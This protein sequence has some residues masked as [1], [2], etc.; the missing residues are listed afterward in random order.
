MQEGELVGPKHEAVAV[1]MSVEAVAYDGIVESLAMSRVD[2]QL[3][4]AS[5]FGP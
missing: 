5:R 3:M 4:G 2:T 1:G